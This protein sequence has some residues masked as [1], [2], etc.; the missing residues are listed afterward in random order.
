[1]RRRC[2]DSERGTIFAASTKRLFIRCWPRILSI[3]VQGF[4]QVEVCASDPRTVVLMLD[5][6]EQAIVCRACKALQKHME[7]GTCM[8]NS[9]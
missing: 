2:R 8:A 4:Q 6:P 3:P 9:W 5:S 7:N 1:M